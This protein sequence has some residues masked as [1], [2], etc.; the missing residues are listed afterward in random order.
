MAVYRKETR[1][2][3]PLSE[4]WEFHSQISG[5]EALTPGFLGLTVDRILGPD[6]EP[7]P[8]VLETGSRIEMALQPLGV[9]PRQ[10]WIAEISS[11]DHDGDTA[12]FV[13]TMAEGPLPTWRHSHSFRADGDETV[14]LD[15]V[16]YELPGGRVGAALGP[17]GGVGFEPMFQYRHWKTRRLLE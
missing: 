1:I 16:T 11:R 17:L 7:N 13:D 10:R 8:A 14:M 4:V 15:E 2:A 6:G 9:G 3:A 12:Q 5:L